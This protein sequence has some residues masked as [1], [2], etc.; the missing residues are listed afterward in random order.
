MYKFCAFDLDGTL[1]DTLESLA[2][3]CNQSLK[4]FGFSEIETEKYKQL[5]GSGA[6][7]LVKGMLKTVGDCECTMFDKV[8][9]DY[10][11]AYHENCLYLA[12]PY[13]GI[14]EM[15]YEL[16]EKGV[17]LA[18]LSN[19][20]HESTVKIIKGIF[21]EDMFC[22]CAGNREGV[23]RKPDPT[24]LLSIAKELSVSAKDGVYV[25]DSGSDME[26]GKNAGM[27]SIGV[28]WGFRDGGELLENG[29]DILVSTPEQITKAVLKTV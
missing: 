22:Y 3:F 25:G 23:P 20:P 9:E 16:K 29:A 14:N 24:A 27:M 11:K 19:K 8:Y 7:N 21:G 5:V 4:K 15:L 10:I 28:L 26:T 18:V 17:K 1:V 12:K 2:Y 6:K 13:D